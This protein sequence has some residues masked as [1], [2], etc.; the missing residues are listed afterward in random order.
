MTVTDPG[1]E[2][3]AA[4]YRKVTLR[5]IPFLFLCYVLAFLDRVNVG[6]AKLNMLSDLGF[7]EKVY[8]LGAGIF[9]LGYFLFEVPS[10]LLL[11]KLGAR[12][13]IARIMITWGLISSAMLWVK[14]PAM[15]YFM[16]F[17]LGVAEAGF[18]PGIILYLTYWY[19]EW[20]RGRIIALFMT[21]VP[22]AGVVGSPLSGWI[23]HTFEGVHGWAGWQLLFFLEGLPSV[24]VGLVVLV[25]LRDGIRQAGWL[26]EE[27]KDLLESRIAGDRAGGPVAP[28][29][30][31][32]KLLTHPG[33]LAL[34]AIYFCI[35]MGLYGAV[36]FW[37]PQLVKDS[38]IKDPLQ[39]GLLTAVPY[40]C[41]VPAMWWLSRS[42]DRTGERRWH[43]A[44][45][46][47]CG[48]AGLILSVVAGHQ[49]A[50]AI[51]A[52]SLAAAGIHSA[53]P[54]FWSMSTGTLR[55]SAAAGIAMINS[56]GGLAGFTGPYAMGWIKDASKGSLD[57]GMYL[58]AG[59]L[60]LGGALVPL[61]VARP[62]KAG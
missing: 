39:I 32:L 62:A 61:V 34:S 41:S 40:L 28:R 52:L 13:W 58:I 43:F 2:K 29:V 53:L 11:E 1:L 3:D 37:L 57:T 14:T 15:F 54:V 31:F 8:G 36:G 46:A 44:A 60:F 49:P 10:N 6:F 48:G 27:E 5:L 56:I 51:L 42:S 9:F 55:G 17:L 35:S 7:S 24:I 21:A 47:A 12:I 22:V 45:S 19:P 4:V 26:T 18:F 30:P 20:R 33:L 38:G 25:Y 50:A 59:I 23:L 16:R